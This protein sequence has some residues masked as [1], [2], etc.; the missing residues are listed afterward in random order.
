MRDAVLKDLVQLDGISVVMTQDVRVPSV[1]SGVDVIIS[2]QD[3]WS[4]WNELMA[5]CDAAWVIA[6]EQGGIL[7]RLTQMATQHSLSILSASV[8]TVALGENKWRLFQALGGTS[9]LTVPTYQSIEHL[10]NDYPFGPWVIKPVDGVGCE[11]AWSFKT[12]DALKDKL[13]TLGEKL[14]CLN[15]FVAQPWVHGEAASLSMLCAHGK[16]HLLAANKQ[17]I[18]VEN[19]KIH[20]AG[21]VVNGLQ[22]QWSRFELLANQLIQAF[23]NLYGYIGVDVIVEPDRVFLVEINPRLTTSYAGLGASLGVNIAKLVLDFL[24]ND[25]VIEEKEWK[26]L[27]VMLRV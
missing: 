9:I 14:D 27:P 6:P 3:V 2:E 19:E 18:S 15:K 7:F 4:Q 21:S 17:L 25:I 20:Y 23:P 5:N 26:R 12:M 13:L 8:D 16:V 1:Y 10:A 22:Q 24:Y 11:D